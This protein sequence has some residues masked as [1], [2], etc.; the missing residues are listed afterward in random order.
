VAA[1]LKHN[2]IVS[3]ISALSSCL[4]LYDGIAIGNQPL[5]T[6]WIRG[7]KAVN[8]PRKLLIPP[9]DL[10][11]VLAALRE[12]PYEP[13]EDADLKWLTMKTAFLVTLLSVRR[14]SEI[15][16]LCSAPPFVTINPRS[17]LLR[18]NPAFCPKTSTEVALQGV[19][20]YSCFPKRI[21]NDL[22]RELRKNCPVR[23]VTL[24][25]Q[26]TADSRHDLQFFVAFGDSRKGKAVC[27]QTLARWVSDVIRLAYQRMGRDDPIRSNPHSTRGIAASWAEFARAGLISICQAATWSNTL[28]FARFYRMDFA[29]SS[30]SSDI[31]QAAQ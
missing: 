25:L 2:T 28:T 30:L 6:R 7:H 4:P 13:L 21:H 27:K 9:W 19:I 22:D 1:N 14:V 31:L 10:A 11:I 17:V 29:G 8:P 5:I 20:E 15:Q 26:R 23:A 12:F 24:Y 16:A 3:H 18:V